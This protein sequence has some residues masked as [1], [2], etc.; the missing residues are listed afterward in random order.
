MIIFVTII[1]ISAYFRAIN[2][3]NQLI[4]LTYKDVH[5]KDKVL[6]ESFANVSRKVEEVKLVAENYIITTDGNKYNYYAIKKIL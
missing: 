5:P 3:I 6:I 1:V 4:M 2:V